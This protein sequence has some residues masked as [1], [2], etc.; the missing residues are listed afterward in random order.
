MSEAAAAWLYSLIRDDTRCQRL[1][2]FSRRDAAS[3]TDASSITAMLSARLSAA[4]S[5]SASARRSRKVPTSIEARSAPP[6]P[7]DAGRRFFMPF[8]LYPRHD[9]ASGRRASLI[10]H[11]KA[12]DAY[13]VVD[14]GSAERRRPA[15]SMTGCRRA[16]VLSWV[17]RGRRC[18]TLAGMVDVTDFGTRGDLIGLGY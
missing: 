16:D 18:F 13:S 2:S 3:R 17:I 7:R 11:V 1:P 15:A 6:R 12:I 5:R 8:N 4:F 14:G 9:D 10:R